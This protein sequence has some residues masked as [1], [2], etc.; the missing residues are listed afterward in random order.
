MSQYGI[1]RNPDGSGYLVDVQADINSR[2][3]TRIMVP[4][5][6]L[7]IA[8]KPD[9]TL[10]PLFE[11][12]GET[13]SMVTQFMA[14]MPVTYLTV[15]PAGRKHRCFYIFYWHFHGSFAPL[16]CKHAEPSGT[17]LK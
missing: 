12:N 7:D 15:H 16:F 10:N 1:Y 11:L 14:A 13:Y 3:N 6:P 17:V 8:P 9:R 4:L 5:L 2:F